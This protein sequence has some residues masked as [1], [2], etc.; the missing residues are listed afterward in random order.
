MN[1]T[2]EETVDAS[3]DDR[4]PTY[5]QSMVA[6]QTNE[7]IK[8]TNTLRRIMKWEFALALYPILYSCVFYASARANN[9]YTLWAAGNVCYILCA[10]LVQ[11][12]V[13]LAQTPKPR[14]AFIDDSVATTTTES[15]FGWLAV[16]VFSFGYIGY[17]LIDTAGL[18]AAT[19]AACFALPVAFL[20]MG[21]WAIKVYFFE[22]LRVLSQRIMQL[23]AMVAKMNT[24]EIQGFALPLYSQSAAVA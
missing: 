24:V 4:Y 23:E 12:V 5:M 8:Y 13:I 11:N 1:T 18:N 10:S 6:H 7:Y 21:F 19:L 20:A 16:R 15:K 2:P 3:V 22:Q 14:I 17:L 9:F